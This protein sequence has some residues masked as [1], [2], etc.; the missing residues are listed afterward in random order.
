MILAT[1]QK[2][3][4]YRG[5]GGSIPI[6]VGLNFSLHRFHVVLLV[7][8]HF[9]LQGLETLPIA[10]IQWGV[11]RTRGKGESVSTRERCIFKYVT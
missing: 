5:G 9:V 10:S 6:W 3:D 4:Y 11:V 2:I 7:L 1:F 8:V